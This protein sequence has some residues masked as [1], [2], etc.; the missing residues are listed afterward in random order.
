MLKFQSISVSEEP[1]R[2]A[3]A[4]FITRKTHDA[5]TEFGRP[6]GVQR[7]RDLRCG[8]AGRWPTGCQP[9]PKWTPSTGESAH[10][11]LYRSSQPTA[12]G[13][14]G[15]WLA[16][17]SQVIRSR[18]LRSFYNS[19]EFVCATMSGCAGGRA[20]RAAQAARQ[21]RSTAGA[22]RNETLN[23]IIIDFVGALQP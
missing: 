17:W 23:P 12:K 13:E 4:D 18:I 19:L 15:A 9:R 2:L 7:R 20:G 14:R 11:H 22:D 1:S 10:V 8:K 6:V 5:R 16:G 3:A 21:E